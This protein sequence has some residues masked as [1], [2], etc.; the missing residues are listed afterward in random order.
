MSIFGLIRNAFKRKSV[1]DNKLP[2]V[3]CNIRQ[4]VS[5]GD[6]IRELAPIKE[7]YSDLI[8]SDKDMADSILSGFNL[9]IAADSLLR[10][11]KGKARREVSP[12]IYWLS[13]KCHYLHNSRR[14]VSSGITHGEWVCC[15]DYCDGREGNPSHQKLSG[16][17][18]PLKEGLK[19]RGKIYLPGAEEGC[20]CNY[21]P[22]LPF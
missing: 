9:K 3:K 4:F 1:E 11:N 14:A 8:F 18:F 22:I 5:E 12:A 17:I 6:V 19:Y 21:K 15:A 16:K 20:R 10:L 2:T 13:S 7:K